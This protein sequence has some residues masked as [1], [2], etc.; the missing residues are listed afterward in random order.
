MDDFIEEENVYS[1]GAR[2]QLV[3]DDALDSREAAFMQGYDDA[4]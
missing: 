1:E 2:E 4:L 3:E